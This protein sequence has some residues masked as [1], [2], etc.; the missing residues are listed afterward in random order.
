MLEIPV[1]GPIV[2][3]RLRVNAA[4]SWLGLRLAGIKQHQVVVC[5][6]P[7]GGTS[8]LY[9]MLSSS[10]QGFRCEPFEQ[11]FIYR[12]HRL[13]NYATKAPL[14]VLHIPRIDELN[15]NRKELVVLV[16]VRD[17]RDILTSRH[18]MI[19]DQ[20]FI[21]HDYSW[22]PQDKSFKKWRYDAPGVVGIYEAIRAIR[23]RSDTTIVRYEDLVADPN[24]VQQTLAE[25]YG[26]GFD[27]NF[28][29]FH[30]RPEKHAYK[31]EGRFAPLDTSL[32]REGLQST[33]ERV[34]RW[35]K[36]PEDV[37]RII[38]QFSQ[39]E[40]LFTILEDF[41]YEADRDWFRRLT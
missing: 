25:F 21:G 22:W 11:Y 18:P 23:T 33:T 41:G 27:G 14:D 9:N 10:L 24:A 31:Y 17:I 36:R 3:A 15:I 4:L 16:V 5:G 29:Q 13:G 12:V 39:C 30:E 1:N 38:T 6:F 7:R 40:M 34:A 2:S 32:V 19:P 35:R 20:Y 37:R 28:R 8:L 26:L